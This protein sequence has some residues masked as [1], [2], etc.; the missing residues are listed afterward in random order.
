MQIEDL[1][2]IIRRVVT[3]VLLSGLVLSGAACAAKPEGGTMIVVRNGGPFDN[4]NIRQLLCPG[5]GNTWVGFNSDSHDYPDSKSQRTYKFNDAVDSDGKRIADSGP[6]EGLRSA[7]GVK[8]TLAGTLYFK[9]KFDCSPEGRKVVQQFD[10]ANANRPEGER[11]WEDW[12]GY[13]ASQFQPVLDNAARNVVLSVDAKKIVSSAA[14]LARDTDAAEKELKNVDNKAN[15]QLIERSLG[16]SLQEQL[17]S[18]LGGVYFTDIVFNLEQ[19]QLPE[20]EDAIAQAQRAYAKVAD[21]RAERLKQQEQVKVEKQ[22]KLVN[23]QKQLGYNKCRSCAKQDEYRALP[24]GLQ[25]YAPG[26]GVAVR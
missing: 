9:T 26:A 10:Q 18:K 6:I 24:E 2:K 12:S 17:K 16:D 23:Q 5:A 11:P 19:P 7:D 22:K 14:L 25:T 4:K 20:V 21:V 3:G 8:V 1:N 15:I 13:L